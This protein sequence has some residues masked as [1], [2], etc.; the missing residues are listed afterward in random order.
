MDG[1][2]PGR[3]RNVATSGMAFTA[4]GQAIKLAVHVAAIMA[5]SRLLGPSEFGVFAMVSPLL[6]L[7]AIIRDAG[8]TSAVLQRQSISDAELTGLFW[9]SIG[10]G[11]ALAALLVAVAPLIARFYGE[12]RLVALVAASSVIVL[13]GSLSLPQMALLNRALR[14]GTLAA[15]DAGSLALG[16]VLGGAVA[17][18]T[19][20]YWALWVVNCTTA[21]AIV[22]ASWCASGWR[23]GR[24][25]SLQGLGD[26]LRVGR[27]VTL[28]SLFDFLLRSVDNVLIGR[29][30][31]GFELG[32]YDRSYR[33]VLLPLIFVC[34][35]LDRLVLPALVRMRDDPQRY[36]KV[37]RLA[38]QAPLLAIMPAM[39]TIMAVPRPVCLVLLGQEWIAA[40]P[41]LAWL[42]LAGALQLI[43][44]SL[45]SL[46][47]SQ[48]RAAE[49]SVL[50]GLGL[51]LACTAFVAG[52]PFGAH[53][54]A[55]A[56]AISEVIR[57][58]LAV[59][60]ATRSGPI[61]AVDV[62]RTVFP[63]LLSA[64]SAFA[65]VSWI[66]DHVP[67][68]PA[69]PIALS[70]AV[71]Y[72]ITGTSLLFTATGRECLKEAA[73]IMADIA[74]SSKGT[75]GYGWLRRRLAPLS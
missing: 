34:A 53:G 57:S 10:W 20:S 3:F 49:L 25:R 12:P 19:D 65:A 54:V 9:I 33:I 68:P 6:A 29:F 30:R 44:S 62:G 70:V 11:G 47:I 40:A 16:Y 38:L 21:F 74:A 14:F 36:R 35:P 67:G 55:A 61:T 58:P 27:S 63:F 26:M 46:L 13:A 51:V 8:L 32:L 52:L 42:A 24:P 71:S 73:T 45:A 15:I 28:A 5:L 64:V 22:A 23:P 69:L 37:Y 31:G 48:G 75:R 7:A 59:W 39:V 4:A 66:G 60:R 1:E 41:M 56:Y 2:Q 18:A 72:A 43:T 17:L 50:N